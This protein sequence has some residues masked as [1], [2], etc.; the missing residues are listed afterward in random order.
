MGK[1]KQFPERRPSLGVLSHDGE[2]IQ[3]ETRPHTNAKPR[4]SHSDDLIPEH[5]HTLSSSRFFFFKGRGNVSSLMKIGYG[6]TGPPA[7]RTTLIASLIFCFEGV[8]GVLAGQ[9]VGNLL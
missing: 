4:F 9:K 8:Q 7:V 5:E 2:F 6:P 3:N 1:V